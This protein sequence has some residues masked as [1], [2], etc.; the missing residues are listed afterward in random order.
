M[1][2]SN[3][4]NITAIA[5]KSKQTE[6]MTGKGIFSNIFPYYVV[7]REY[8]RS[9]IEVEVGEENQVALML[10]LPGAMW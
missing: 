2:T 7:M 4:E 6:G 9:W 3:T 1:W 8:L 10:V 5:A